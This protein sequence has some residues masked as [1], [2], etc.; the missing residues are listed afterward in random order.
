M[1]DLRK[2]TAD[3][4][5]L[6]EDVDYLTALAEPDLTAGTPS[7]TTT[8]SWP[9]A[10]SA[11]GV[12]AHIWHNLTPTEAA[13]AWQTLTGWVDWLTLRYALDDTIPSC[14]YRHGPIVDELDALRA[15]WTSAYPDPNAHPTAA[16]A[17]LE[18]LNRTLARVREWD[19]YGCT[20]GTH[21]DDPPAT[22]DNHE[23][24]GREQWLFAD[25]NARAAARS[26]TSN[27]KSVE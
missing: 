10:P 26:A 3:L 7:G 13:R 20:S 8:G 22:S 1:T 17:W 25:I 6:R 5:Q 19:R 18:I 14:W 15:A 24:D 21:H 4:N 12:A 16:I 23:T 9:A 11:P 27:T 2:I